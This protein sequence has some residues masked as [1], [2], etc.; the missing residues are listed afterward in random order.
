MSEKFIVTPDDVEEVLIKN[1]IQVNEDLVMNA[2]YSLDYDMVENAPVYSQID[3][4]F[5]AVELAK[6]EIEVQLRDNGFLNENN[7]FSYL[8]NYDYAFDKLNFFKDENNNWNGSK[9]LPVSEEASKDVES[10]LKF[11]QKLKIEQPGLCTGGDGSVGVIWCKD[12]IYVACDFDGR[13]KSYTF[14]VSKSEDLIFSGQSTLD[15]MD[16]NLLEFLLINFI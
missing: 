7:K 12:N 10:F 5:E 3:D 8:P 15:S 9:D 16:K 4:Q 6:A 2:Y 13:D 14:I 11:V 1:G